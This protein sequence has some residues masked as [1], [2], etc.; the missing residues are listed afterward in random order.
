MACCFKPSVGAKLLSMVPLLQMTRSGRCP[1]WVR[2]LADTP[3]I[4]FSHRITGLQRIYER[5]HQLV[6]VKNKWIY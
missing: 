5:R 1:A 2:K 4:R 6:Q 3:G